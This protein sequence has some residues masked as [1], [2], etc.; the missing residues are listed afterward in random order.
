M[1]T[2]TEETE[3]VQQEYAAWVVGTQADVADAV[4]I[5]RNRGYVHNEQMEASKE[6]MRVH[7]SKCR[8]IYITAWD[9]DLW[10][11]QET[12]MGKKWGVK[13]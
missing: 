2:M 6:A 3:V 13:R 12:A 10:L 9:M 8:A 11:G 4:M 7:M 5:A 1:F